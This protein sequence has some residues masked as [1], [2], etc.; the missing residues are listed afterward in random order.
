MEKIPEPFVL[1]YRRPGEDYKSLPD[2]LDIIYDRLNSL[3]DK[4]K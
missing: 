4:V 3:D 2:V 1:E